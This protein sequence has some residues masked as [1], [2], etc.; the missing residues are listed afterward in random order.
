[1]IAQ[2]GRAAD[3]Q[4]NGLQ[5]TMACKSMDP[6]IVAALADLAAVP[7]DDAEIAA[8]IAAGASAAIAAVRTQMLAGT[9][10][11]PSLFEYEPGNYLATLERLAR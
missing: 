11:D 8:R 10:D 4:E 3:L 2:S 1:V 5:S 6:G 7:L 9:L